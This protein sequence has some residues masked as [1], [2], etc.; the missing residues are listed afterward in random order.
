MLSIRID[1]NIENRLL[2]LAT[3]TG[4]T[5]TFYAKEAIITYLDE[6]EDYYIA[7]DRLNNPGMI[8]SLEEIENGKDLEN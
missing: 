5:K 6:M 3:K 7:K 4:R 8:W 2:N 1:K